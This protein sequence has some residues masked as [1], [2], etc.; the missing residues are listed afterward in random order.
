[1]PRD[2]SDE[3]T[4]Q[5]PTTVTDPVF[6]CPDHGFTTAPEPPTP[7]CPDCGQPTQTVL[8][9]ERRRRLSKFASGALRHFP[10]DA[11]LELDSGGW[12]DYDDLVR[13][14]TQK[15]DWAERE[16]LDAVVATDPKGRLESEDGRIRASYG[17]SVDVNLDAGESEDRERGSEQNE[18]PDRL[19]HGT[20]PDNLD[21]IL[22]E[23]LKPMGRQQVHLSGTTEEA[24]EVG[25][26]H[27][28]NPVV[29]EVDASGM[30]ADGLTV[31]K[32]GTETY[33]TDKVPPQY[34]AVQEK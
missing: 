13:A 28:A 3:I 16:H 4:Y 25:Q 33:T 26:R 24:H 5:S 11:G 15:Y 34:L 10:D 7:K 12:T 32:R 27:A 29:L 30:V 18:I 9:G 8:S 21:A 6:R 14:V 31:A 22:S 19:Y 17:H 2:L 20:D 23:G 1:M